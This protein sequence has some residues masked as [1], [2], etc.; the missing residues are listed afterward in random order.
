[1]THTIY[2]KQATLPQREQCRLLLNELIRLADQTV[3][4]AE[5][6]DANEV[7]RLVDRRG[8]CWLL[9]NDLIEGKQLGHWGL[10]PLATTMKAKEA[11]AQHAIENTIRRV[12]TRMQARAL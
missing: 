8:N 10:G 4:A 3:V 7:S 9:L 6:P 11:K 12:H 2:T 1:M 5:K